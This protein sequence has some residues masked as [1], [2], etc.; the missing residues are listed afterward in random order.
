MPKRIEPPTLYWCAKCQRVFNMWK[1]PS[2][3]PFC[4]AQSDKIQVRTSG[5]L[6]EIPG[7][8]CEHCGEEIPEGKEHRLED[9][10]TI[11]CETCW[12]VLE[13]A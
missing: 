6:E 12:R 11:L 2:E 9:G 1:R 7:Y 8:Y 10:E 4:S 3:C 13:H 5:D